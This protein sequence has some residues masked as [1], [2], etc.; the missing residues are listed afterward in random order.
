[1]SKNPPFHVTVLKRDGSFETTYYKTEDEFG[2]ALANE[3]YPFL[4]DGYRLVKQNRFSV[5]LKEGSYMEVSE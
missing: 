4:G 1:M 5:L 2:E 3:F